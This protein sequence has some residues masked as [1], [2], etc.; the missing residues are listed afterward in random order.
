MGNSIPRITTQ[1][2]HN[3]AKILANQPYLEVGE[4]LSQGMQNLG[5]NEQE[6]VKIIQIA[7]NTNTGTL[8]WADL[9]TYFKNPK[10][11]EDPNDTLE[12]LKRV[13]LYKNPPNPDAVS[14]QIRMLDYIDEAG[15]IAGQIALTHYQPKKPS[16]LPPIIFVPGLDHPA[17]AYPELW[18][19]I[20][21]LEGRDVI[22]MDLFGNGG[23]MLG[24]RDSIDADTL[25]RELKFVIG[26]IIPEGSGFCLADFSFGSSPVRKLKSEYDRKNKKFDNELGNRQLVHTLH[27]APMRARREGL[28]GV[29]FSKDFVY[30]LFSDVLFN[31]QLSWGNWNNDPFFN[32]SKPAERTFLRQVVARNALP[33]NI[34]GPLSFALSTDVRPY[35]DELK[36]GD[37]S[38]IFHRDD[39]IFPLD[40]PEAWENIPGVYLVEGDHSALAGEVT[41]E[42][43]ETVRKALRPHETNEKNQFN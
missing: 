11:L 23:S 14:Q 5:L 35:L 29:G 10:L 25:Y 32:K 1:D 34:L 24:K 40:N 27:I 3:V 41:L 4:A 21:A 16:G 43:I 38:V 30:P 17:P 7:G 26:N 33:A 13:L 37:T 28:A 22:I 12:E 31:Q 20:A 39:K 19:A 2:I 9:Y 42:Y 6:R 15:N 8:E 18:P 36:D